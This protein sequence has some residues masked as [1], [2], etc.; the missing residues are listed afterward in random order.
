MTANWKKKHHCILSHGPQYPIHVQ[1]N[2]Q[3]DHKNGLFVCPSV[4]SQ[5][6]SAADIKLGMLTKLC[7]TPLVLRM[8]VL[9][10]SPIEQIRCGISQ[11][12]MCWNPQGT[13]GL[14]SSLESHSETP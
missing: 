3:S 8:T 4:N 14:L 6:E 11:T 1:L 10:I 2:Q 12:T 7:I 13:L 5:L 9:P